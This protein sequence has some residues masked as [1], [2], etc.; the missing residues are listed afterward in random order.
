MAI[1]F[2][3]YLQ[4]IRASK[5]VTQQEVLDFLIEGNDVFSK[6]DLTTYSRWERGV[7]KP[8]LSKQILAA[9]LLGSDIMELLDIETNNSKIEANL[10]AYV[11]SK[12]R[13]H[14]TQDSKEFEMNHYESLA[15]QTELS[16]QLETFH[17]DYLNI[18]FNSEIIQKS[19]LKLDT[20]H[21][22]SGQLVGHLLYGFVDSNVDISLISPNNLENCPFINKE[23]CSDKGCK[24]RSVSMYIVSA[25]SSLSATRM[26]IL[27]LLLERIKETHCT[28]D[29]Y[30]NCHDQDGF[31]LFDKNSDHQVINK[32]RI[33]ESGGIRL[34]GKNYKFLQLKLS[35]ESLLASDL[36]K[37]LFSL[38]KNGF[39]ELLDDTV[40]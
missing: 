26:T 8:K 38:Y 10:L 12:S 31:T 16:E 9:R 34:Y 7:T 4:N 6:L 11:I 2:S 15:E 5:G 20:F 37:Y 32:G 19:Q 24:G 30:V 29:F 35:S 3:E 33:V 21:D 17:S 25:Y 13:N 40:G 28:R 18:N 22:A 14:Y 1:T 23:E 36:V 39:D 27:L